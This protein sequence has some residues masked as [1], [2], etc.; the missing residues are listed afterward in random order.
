MTTPRPICTCPPPALPT[1]L[2]RSTVLIAA[3]VAAAREPEEPRYFSSIPEVPTPRVQMETLNGNTDAVA[4]LPS[5]MESPAGSP[6]TGDNLAQPPREPSLRSSTSQGEA[7]D[8][9]AAATVAAPCS[10]AAAT[11]DTTYTNSC[12]SCLPGC[13]G[14]GGNGGVFG[15]W[16]R[17]RARERGDSRSDS[18]DSAS[19]RED[20][21]R[22]QGSGSVAAEKT[23][24]GT[25]KRS[26]RGRPGSAWGS[27]SETAAKT[28][29]GE[30]AKWATVVFS[31]EEAESLATRDWGGGI[32]AAKDTWKELVPVGGGGKAG[33]AGG[34]GPGGGFGV[35]GSAVRLR[36]RFVPLW[37]CIA[38]SRMVIH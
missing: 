19:V 1:T 14:R 24:D 34:K 20:D 36:L 17:R 18:S 22:S 5:T 32:G 8:T 26:W 38:V 30:A 27:N 29:A 11:V 37:D 10:T 25:K 3:P 23:T 7:E 15:R 28:A 35:A 31:L 2:E 13:G 9:A 12:T 21:V 16:R 4:A 6:P 33:V